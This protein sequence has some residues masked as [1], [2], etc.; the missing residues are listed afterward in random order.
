MYQFSKN[1][2]LTAFGLI[3][4][5]LLGIGYGFYSAPS[6]VVEAKAMV[7]HGDDHGN[8]H[9]TAHADNHGDTTKKEAHT[10]ATHKES[11]TKDG[12][13]TDSQEDEHGEHL[14]HQMQNR[15]WSAF[16]VALFFFLGISL[17]V[18]AFYAAQR[19]A[20]AGCLLFYSE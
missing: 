5:G 2:K 18:L 4:V 6:T 15:P 8:D 1:L 14:L 3:I 9:G 12:H 11:H 17:L 10:D 16:Y 13:A 19:V 7:A 20:K